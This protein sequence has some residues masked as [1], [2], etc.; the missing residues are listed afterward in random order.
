ML[1]PEAVVALAAAGP[2]PPTIPQ[3]HGGPP[4][5]SHLVGHP[6][7]GIPPQIQVHY[8]TIFQATIMPQQGHQQDQM[9]QVQVPDQQ[10]IHQQVYHYQQEI[11][12]QTK[13]PE[14]LMDEDVKSNLPPTVAQTAV[15]C[16]NF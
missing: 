13:N 10:Q 4:Q 3:N 9:E 2:P 14:S 8:P 12:I 7:V 5:A 15:S 16:F 11:Q 6:Q 1:N